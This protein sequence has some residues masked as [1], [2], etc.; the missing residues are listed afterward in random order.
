MVV[1]QKAKE[2]TERVKA[3]VKEDMKDN[4]DRVTLS[5]LFQ[6]RQSPTP[7]PNP[8]STVSRSKPKETITKLFRRR[9]HS[10]PP[11]IR[12]K[13]KVVVHHAQTCKSYK[14]KR[15]I[16]DRLFASGKA[17]PTSA[18]ERAREV[19]MN[20]EPEFPSFVKV[21]L[22]SHVTNGFWLGLPAKF[23]LSNL[24]KQDTTIA[25]V[26]EN[27]QE[28]PAKYL[29]QRVGLSG[30]WRGFSI[31][32][33]LVEGDVLIFQLV[34]VTKFKV[35][36]IRENDLTE[37]DGALGLLNLDGRARKMDS[38]DED[39]PPFLP[40]HAEKRQKTNHPISISHLGMPSGEKSEN[41]GQEVGPEVLETG[42]R[43]SGANVEFKDVNNF[44]DF[45]IVVN[46]LI[47]NSELPEH[48]RKNYYQLCCSQKA[49]LHDNLLEGINCLLS[50]GVISE[51]VNIADAIRAC[52][53]TTASKDDLMKWDKSLQAFEYLGMNVGFLRSRLNC[54]VDLA[55]GSEEAVALRRYKEG[56]VAQSQ[57]E[58]NIRNLEVKLVQLK[59]T[60]KRYED[61]IKSLKVQTEML[62]I[63]F[64]EKVN[65]PW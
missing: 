28:T 39:P 12:K 48:V 11:R 57:L 25:L 61:E 20:L 29:A 14:Q 30:G 21:M 7:S 50:S 32:H 44:E 23:C 56:M 52:K 15:S 37:V 9:W 47:I 17:N 27:G 16:I 53:L 60:H 24:P 43:F 35:Y 41:D 59:E 45:N 38:A 58:E 4:E 8:T 22:R 5:R 63:K 34:T 40:V 26:D 13:Q 65:S 31:A 64:Q 1:D 62:E 49:F 18:M 33:K 10:A 51:T 6:T 42:I 2:D 55:F 19:R 36:I 3:E 54:L 46:D